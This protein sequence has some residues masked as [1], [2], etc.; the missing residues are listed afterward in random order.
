MRPRLGSRREADRGRVRL[1]AAVEDLFD[2]AGRWSVGSSSYEIQGVVE[3]LPMSAV[4]RLA[5]WGEREG[6]R[7]GVDRWSALVGPTLDASWAMNGPVDELAAWVAVSSAR[8]NGRQSLRIGPGGLES[9]GDWPG[10][11]DRPGQPEASA[12]TLSVTP[13]SWSAVLGPE[14][15]EL[16]GPFRLRAAV[17]S[18]VVPART[19]GTGE[20]ATRGGE[21]ERSPEP[22]ESRESQAGGG[23]GVDWSRTRYEVVLEPV[24]GDGVEVKWPG[25]PALRMTPRFV[26]SSEAADAW[27]EL[28]MLAGLGV[29]AEEEELRAGLRVEF[30]ATRRMRGARG[31][32]CG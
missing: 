22:V 8:L 3:A 21:E 7:E 1:T 16:R 29:G 4:D 24:G 20:T 10:N 30:G 28:R 32:G 17:Q 26:L 15:G 12:L 5:G 6:A 2:A 11:G 27:V 9:G 25:R 23:G 14:A 18:L 13:A 19:A 31:G